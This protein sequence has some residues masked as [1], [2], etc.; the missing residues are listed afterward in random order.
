MR[1]LVRRLKPA[2]KHSSLSA[3]P[4][5]TDRDGAKQSQTQPQS[6]Q[7]S[8]HV[9]CESQNNAGASR[10]E[11]DVV[12]ALPISQSSLQEELWN[13]AHDALREDSPGIF[14]AYEKILSGRLKRPANLA[15]DLAA[16]ENEIKETRPERRDQMKQLVEAGL[17]AQD[18]YN[19]HTK[20]ID[21]GMTTVNSIRS[22]IEHS[23][24]SSSEAAI[25]WVG[26]SLVLEVSCSIFSNEDGGS[27]WVIYSPVLHT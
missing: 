18:R 7:F 25:A 14:E 24:K 12:S 27:S 11:E 4:N 6:K 16:E 22:I 3:S 23:V 5:L 13:D 15:E 10:I 20:R 2:K 19:S 17:E 26:V 9:D 21:H 1:A 8:S